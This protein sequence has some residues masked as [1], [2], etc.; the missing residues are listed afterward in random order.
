V[1][2]PHTLEGGTKPSSSYTHRDERK[3]PLFTLLLGLAERVLGSA[4]PSYGDADARLDPE[5]SLAPQASLIYP[6]AIRLE[7]P[8]IEKRHATY[9]KVSS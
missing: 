1:M 8:L 2:N 4:S 5:I 7:H 3:N 6:A 9:V